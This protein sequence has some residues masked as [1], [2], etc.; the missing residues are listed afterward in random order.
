MTIKHSFWQSLDRQK[1]R[2]LCFQT[3][4]ADV[5]CV[6]H[7]IWSQ[8]LEANLTPPIVS[9]EPCC[10]TYI[11]NQETWCI[12]VAE[13]KEASHLKI[14][15]FN[16]ACDIVPDQR[17]SQWPIETAPNKLPLWKRTNLPIPPLNWKYCRNAFLLDRN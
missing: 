2:P 16:C 7:Q 1:H 13:K 17:F 11:E 14:N 4:V 12:C 5:E 3:L 15:K 6:D 8:I 10:P 9:H